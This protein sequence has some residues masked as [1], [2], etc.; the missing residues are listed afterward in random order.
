VN[1]VA[2]PAHLRL[3]S[4]SFNDKNNSDK[5]TNKQMRTLTSLRRTYD[6]QMRE[7]SSFAGQRAP[8]HDRRRRLHSE[9]R[10]RD[11]DAELLYRGPQVVCLRHRGLV[12][13]RE[14]VVRR[15]I[16]RYW[17]GAP[18]QYEV[19]EP[20]A[21]VAAGEPEPVSA[22]IANMSA[23]AQS[24]TAGVG[25]G[26]AEP[27]SASTAT[28]T[29]TGIRY[30]DDEARSLP[31]LDTVEGVPVP[32][33]EV[34]SGS[35][36]TVTLTNDDALAIAG[37]AK[38][39]GCVPALY[40]RFTV[41]AALPQDEAN[42]WCVYVLRSDTADADADGYVGVT[43]FVDRH[44]RLAAHN[45]KAQHGASATVSGRP[46]RMVCALR[47]LALRHPNKLRTL[48][49][50]CGKVR[51]V[52]GFVAPRAAW[53]LSCRRVGAKVCTYVCALDCERERPA[54]V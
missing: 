22:Q 9:H 7:R 5:N 34:L 16:R 2:A 23:A 14:C 43:P 47:G 29:S 48:P 40:H 31:L 36:A 54:R 49:K 26:A 30:L 42:E 12:A 32:Q 46:W 37:A 18:I 35:T 19:W 4:V 41:L 52:R 28:T 27:T 13:P 38:C 11:G 21:S 3:I 1:L 44:G 39:G 15:T 51:R 8:L 33:I 53:T 20:A 10:Y 6:Y 50:G 24:T 45:G 25:G 17:P